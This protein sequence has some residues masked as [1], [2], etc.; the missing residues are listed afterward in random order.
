M[1]ESILK[2]WT[3]KIANSINLLLV[4]QDDTVLNDLMILL[5]QINIVDTPKG[6]FNTHTTNHQHGENLTAAAYPTLCTLKAANFYWSKTDVS[7]NA[8]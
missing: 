4:G 3:S 5:R 8:S 7:C 6:A 2:H 1:A